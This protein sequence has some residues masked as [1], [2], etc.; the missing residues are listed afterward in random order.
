MYISEPGSLDFNK[1]LTWVLK[2]GAVMRGSCAPTE[3]CVCALQCQTDAWMERTVL[4][5]SDAQQQSSAAPGSQ[6]PTCSRAKNLLCGLGRGWN[7]H[8]QQKVWLGGETRQ[9]CAGGGW[10]RPVLSVLTA[11]SFVSLCK[12][13]LLLTCLGFLAEGRCG[14]SKEKGKMLVKKVF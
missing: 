2:C 12:L 14:F 4:G 6:E 8:R 7:Q 11:K 10:G 13:G 5:S 3:L 1:M 9:K